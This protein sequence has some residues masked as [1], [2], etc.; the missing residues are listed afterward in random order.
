MWGAGLCQRQQRQCTGFSFLRL[1]PAHPFLPTPCP[2]RWK[3][4][5]TVTV[6]AE[7]RSPHSCSLQPAAGMGQEQ[8]W[9]SFPCLHQLGTLVMGVRGGEGWGVTSFSVCFW[10]AGT[11]RMGSREQVQDEETH[12]LLLP[13]L[14]EPGT[15]C[16]H[17]P[18]LE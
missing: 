18:R 2:G 17:N 9:G 4:H 1:L 8:L 7:L 14:V 11:P 10:P 15:L 13:S 5:A 16:S 6:P 12:P 3:L